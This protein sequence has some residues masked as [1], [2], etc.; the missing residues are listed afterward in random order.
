MP[1][2]PSPYSNGPVLISGSVGQR[3]EQG[4]SF[5]GLAFSLSQL[6]DHRAAWDSY[7]LALQAARDSGKNERVSLELREGVA[8]TG[9]PR[10]HDAGRVC[11]T[12]NLRRSF[13]LFSLGDIKGHWQA[14]EGLGAAAARL[15]QH[16][17]ALKY[18]KEALALCQVR[19]SVMACLPASL[20]SP[21]LRLIL[22]P[23]SWLPPRIY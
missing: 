13:G 23:R 17:Q 10:V 20:S 12:G 8:K 21:S 11:G 22:R 16:D 1:Q 6:G 14:C 5:S 3:W 4:R 19:P 7:L 18:Y 9:R 2:Q 15:G